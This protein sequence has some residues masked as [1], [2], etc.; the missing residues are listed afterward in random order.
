MAAVAAQPKL[1]TAVCDS[2][3][4]RQPLRGMIRSRATGHRYCPLQDWDECERITAQRKAREKE[5]HG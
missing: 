5:Q 3:G 2:C 1:P 4:R